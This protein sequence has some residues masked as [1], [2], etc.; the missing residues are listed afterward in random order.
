MGHI[1]EKLVL[2]GTH[3]LRGVC[4]R[5]VC[6]FPL[7][8]GLCNR[9]VPGIGSWEWDPV[10]CLRCL[11]PR[12]VFAGFVGSGA[13]NPPNPGSGGG[14][15]SMLVRSSPTEKLEKKRERRKEAGNRGVDRGWGSM[16]L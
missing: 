10:E 1:E 16:D 5:G 11:W 9:G 14:N 3:S 12:G 15:V 7:P 8:R 6:V 2:E 4:S 13:A